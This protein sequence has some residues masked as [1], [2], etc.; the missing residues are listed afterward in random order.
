MRMT[1]PCSPAGARPTPYVQPVVNRVNVHGRRQYIAATGP[2]ISAG[3]AGGYTLT[4]DGQVG[5]TWP[6]VRISGIMGT[7]RPACSPALE[8]LV[9][10]FA[11]RS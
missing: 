5:A 1:S 2:S 4:V 6:Q 9:L 3:A 11:R 7:V 8:R 10:R